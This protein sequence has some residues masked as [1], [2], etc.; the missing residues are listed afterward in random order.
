MPEFLC[1][2]IE[3]GCEQ[4][5][6]YFDDAEAAS[7]F[8]KDYE[9]GCLDEAIIEVATSD[10]YRDLLESKLNEDSPPTAFIVKQLLDRTGS[11]IDAIKMIVDY[12]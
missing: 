5:D 6:R 2:L 11:K 8:L 9:T 12:F 4:L 7:K 3:F 10:P 1:K